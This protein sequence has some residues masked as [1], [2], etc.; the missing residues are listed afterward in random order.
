LVDGPGD[1]VLTGG[2]GRDIMNGGAGADR[3]DFNA[4]TE[5][6]TTFATRDQIVGFEQGS[7]TI[8]FSTIDAN[9]ARWGNQA[10]AF[11]GDD[12]FHGVAGEL[13]Q[14]IVNGNTI[15]SGDI[16]GDAAADFQLQLNEAFTLTL[17]DFIL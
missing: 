1:D 9:T 8:D 6:G 10:F 15:V 2:S 12:A 16:N 13:R 14:Q 5:S 4:S 7:D 11:I 17:N 3:F